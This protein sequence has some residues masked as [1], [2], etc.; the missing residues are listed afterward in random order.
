MAPLRSR[1]GGFFFFGF[2]NR[3]LPSQAG[4]VLEDRRQQLAD[5]GVD[6]HVPPELADRH[7]RVHRVD[8]GVDRLVAAGA[9]ERRAEDALA[10]LLD[11]DLEEALGL[12]PL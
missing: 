12:A 3:G 4:E 1:F 7:A 6:A 10:A 8:E 5:V 9:E 2:Q 11:V